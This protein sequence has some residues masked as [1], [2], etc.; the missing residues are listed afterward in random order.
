MSLMSQSQLAEAGKGWSGEG[1][2][3]PAAKGW[4]STVAAFSC[5][6]EDPYASNVRLG[7][8]VG[9]EV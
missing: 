5:G 1:G 6:R 8:R 7:Q 2:F 4:H 3:G 9:P